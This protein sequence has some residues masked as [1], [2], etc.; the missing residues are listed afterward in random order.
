[1]LVGLL[2]VKQTQSCKLGLNVSYRA[3]M[4]LIVVMHCPTYL[5]FMHAAVMPGTKLQEHCGSEKTWVYSTV[6]FAEEEMKMEL[7]AL[8]FAN[9]ERAARAATAY[10]G[11]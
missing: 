6:D 3:C 11:V 1:M 8:R 7:F 5:T 9:V 2:T 4:Q 10:S